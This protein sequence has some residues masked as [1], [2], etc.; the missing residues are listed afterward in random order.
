MKKI[1]KNS[2]VIALSL[3]TILGTSCS[4]NAGNPADNSSATSEE[5]EENV[6]ESKNNSDNKKE[7]VVKIVNQE[8]EA[9]KQEE[10]MYSFVVNDV[11]ITP[12]AEAEDII[13]KL[14]E[15]NSF[16]EAPSCVFSGKDKV[17]SFSGYDVNTAPYKG[18]EVIVGVFF[19]E[20]GEAKTA[21]GIGIG[22]S[23]QEVKD[24]YGEPQK[25]NAGQMIWENEEVE[26]SIVAINDEVTAVSY[27]GKFE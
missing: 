4:S 25:E 17:Y 20:D 15:P 10:E 5:V 7:K 8:A 11:V 13:A 21:K 2:L 22:S 27:L 16:Y 1:V 9:E 26:F 23:L 6:S 12:G 24:N 3:A 18:K 14:G 19:N